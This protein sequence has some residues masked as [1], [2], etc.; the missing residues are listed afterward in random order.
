MKDVK[1]SDKQLKSLAKFVD[2]Y[3]TALAMHDKVR[4]IEDEWCH[5][6]GWDVNIHALGKAGNIYAVVH[7][8]TRGRDGYQVTEMESMARI[9]MWR[10]NR[11]GD[12]R[13]VGYKSPKK[14]TTKLINNKK[15]VSRK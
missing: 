10:E 13:M 4:D 11:M 2:G 5:Y 12:W 6:D 8:T 1:I 7:P 3:L 14:S 9:G 15:K